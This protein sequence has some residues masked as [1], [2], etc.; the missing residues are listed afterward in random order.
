[1]KKIF[2]GILTLVLFVFI[3]GCARNTDPQFSIRN[4]QANKVDVKIQTSLGNKI[5]INDVEPGQTTAYQT[6]TEG[7]ITATDVIRN[8][9]VS[10]LAEKNTRYTIVISGDKPPSVAV[11]Q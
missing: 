6:A 11:D 7:N 3:Y 10:F 9:S 4:E 8:E 5:T 1:M 2:V